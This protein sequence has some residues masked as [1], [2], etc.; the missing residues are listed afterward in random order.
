MW[1]GTICWKDGFGGRASGPRKLPFKFNW[2]C[3]CVVPGSMSPMGQR[4]LCVS[5][6]ECDFLVFETRV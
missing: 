6:C 4:C 2:L 1:R 5:V 3:P